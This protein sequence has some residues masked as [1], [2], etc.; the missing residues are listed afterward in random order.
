MANKNK[1]LVWKG[2]KE[3]HLQPGFPK[4]TMR[5]DASVYRFRYKGPMAKLEKEQ[6]T[7]GANV[8]G[9]PSLYRVEEV[10]IEPDAAGRNGPGTMTFSLVAET[11]GGSGTAVGEEIVE[12]DAGGLEKS[13]FDNPAFAG[14]T[15][16]S[17][18]VCEKR[19]PKTRACPVRLSRD[20]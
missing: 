5:G 17:A 13:I 15:K 1:K 20:R 6:P 18:R 19:W 11:Y 14:L 7:Y 4:Y 8:R 9:Y 3:I 12:I 16:W 10:E 2:S